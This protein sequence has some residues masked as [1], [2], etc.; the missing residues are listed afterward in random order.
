M[1]IY[2]K[3]KQNFLGSFMST[4]CCHNGKHGRE[5]QGMFYR[6]KK[7]LNSCKWKRILL[8]LFSKFDTLGAET[9]A[10]RK[11]REI[12]AFCE[13]KLSRIGQNRIFRILNVR[14]WTEKL[15][16]FLLFKGNVCI[17]IEIKERKKPYY[18]KLLLY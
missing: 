18:L 15:N 8:E 11:I 10:S 3:H 17:Q 2:P 5:N 6:A 12:F 7:A 4:Q 1:V 13:H 14:E 9:F 16:F